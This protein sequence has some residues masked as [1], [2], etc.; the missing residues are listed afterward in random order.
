[1]SERIKK[2]PHLH[3][4]SENGESLR[5]EDLF[6]DEDERVL[7]L[8]DLLDDEGLTDGPSDKHRNQQSNN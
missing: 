8:V 6:Y 7:H 3:I 2:Q 1:M 5:E 4:A